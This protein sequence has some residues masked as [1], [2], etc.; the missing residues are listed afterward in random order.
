[1]SQSRIL[2]ALITL[3]FP[4]VM[5]SSCTAPSPTQTPTPSPTPSA[6]IPTVVTLPTEGVIFP[7]RIALEP[8]V[9]APGQPTY[10]V[11]AAD[12]SSRIFLVEKQGRVRVIKD[13]KL[14]ETPFLDIVDLVESRGSEQGLF[15]I[16]F[17]PNYITNGELYVNYTAKAGNGD[18]IVARYRVSADPDVVDPGSAQVV[19]QIDQPAANHN[20]GQLQFG[21]DGYLYI[22]MGDGGSSGDP[23]GNAQNLDVLLGKM[24][25]LA[26]RGEATYSIPPDNPFLGRNDARPEIW[27]YGLRNPWRF[28]FDRATSDLYIADVGQNAWEEVNFQSRSSHGGENYGWDILEGTHC[29]EP[30]RGCDRGSTVLPVA[31]YGHDQGCSVTG[32]YVYRGKKYPTLRGI[33]FFA[34]YCSGRIWGLRQADGGNWEMAQLLKT[35]VRVSSFGEDAAGELYVLDLGGKVYHLTGRE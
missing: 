6:I 34:D 11:D 4:G 23:W 1:M 2:L 9:S 16:A 7:P 15:S 19:L 29:F 21:P 20:G 5:L 18:T 10:L 27:A 31:E 14:L 32:G 24:L 12:G 17:D 8:F 3:I 13:S 33:Y 26:V 28:S 22:G 30:P 25:R 35:D